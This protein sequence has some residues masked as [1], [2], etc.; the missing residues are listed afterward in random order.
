[1][2]EPFFSVVFA[3]EGTFSLT[4]AALLLSGLGGQHR[5]LGAGLL[6]KLLQVHLSQLLGQQLQLM[7]H[8]LQSNT[9]GGD[10]VNQLQSDSPNVACEHFL[11]LHGP[12]ELVYYEN[13]T[14]SDVTSGSPVVS[15]CSVRGTCPQPCCC[16]P[17]GQPVSPGI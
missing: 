16:S 9:R 3:T 14:S 13:A 17:A 1:M 12:S 5:D 8:V 2:M 11:A 15:C 4:A 10:E 7:L 6:D